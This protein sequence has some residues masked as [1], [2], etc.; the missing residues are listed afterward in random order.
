MRV[1]CI[2]SSLLLHKTHQIFQQLFHIAKCTRA[3]VFEKL[4]YDLK[5]SLASI[6]YEDLNYGTT[7]HIDRAPLG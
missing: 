4:C 6:Q 1:N 7:M 2:G 3:D 5:R